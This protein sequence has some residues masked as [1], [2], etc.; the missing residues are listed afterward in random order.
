MGKGRGSV[1]TFVARIRCGDLIYQLS[2]LP[3]PLGV[4][5]LKKAQYKL[6]IKTQILVRSQPT[7]VV[8][9]SL[10]V[11]LFTVILYILQCLSWIS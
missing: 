4:Q 3:T 5:A 9:G 6:G 2:N 8:K 1:S 10:F 7:K 11:L